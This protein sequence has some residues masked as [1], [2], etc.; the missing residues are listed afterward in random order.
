MLDT[1][2]LPTLLVRQAALL[3]LAEG[4]EMVVHAT[5]VDR[6]LSGLK[7]EDVLLL[8]TKAKRYLTVENMPE[9]P[10]DWARLIIPIEVDDQIIGMWIFGRRDPDDFYPKAD[11]DLSSTLG[12]Q[13]AV[14]LETI[15]LFEAAQVRAREMER[16][17]LELRRA[18]RLKSDLLRNV[19]HELRTPLTTIHGFTELMIDD[20]T[21]SEEH[22]EYP[23]GHHPQHDRW[24]RW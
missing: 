13:L 23:C 1:E 3:W 9:A 19:T 21:L 17:N 7:N 24:C 8:K 4:Q 10:F 14:A 5:G 6:D 12:N 15:R 2:I 11:I 18:D 20:E 16:L 22:G